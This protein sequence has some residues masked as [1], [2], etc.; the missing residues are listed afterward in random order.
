M[1]GL[2]T[3][4][5]HGIGRKT[6]SK[7]ESLGIR[8]VAELVAADE[9]VLARRFGPNTGPWLRVLAAGE[10]PSEVTSEPYVARGHGRERTFQRDLTDLHEIRG[11][12]AKL[13]RE[14][15][16]DL[17]KEGRPAI[18]IIVK[19]RFAPFFTSTHSVPADDP[20]SDPEV[21]EA[22]ALRALE[23]F[24]LDR[25]IRLLGVRAEMPGPENPNGH[26]V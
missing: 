3:D 26:R 4:A 19:V 2:T 21:L 1:G 18:R 25:P 15:C 23:R 7:L 16:V 6:A 10:D 17:E 14:V 13:A 12:V 9:D 5:L 24:E 20:T 22:L 11:E 8:T